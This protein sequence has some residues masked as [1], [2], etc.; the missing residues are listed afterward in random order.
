MLELPAAAAAATAAAAA[1]LVQACASQPA[2]AAA[3]LAV[4]GLAVLE[5]TRQDVGRDPEGAGAGASQR[6]PQIAGPLQL[7]LAASQVGLRA[8]HWTMRVLGSSEPA[9]ATTSGLIMPAWKGGHRTYTLDPPNNSDTLTI[10]PLAG[11]LSSIH[12][13]FQCR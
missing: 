10:T 3:A 6:E 4:A 1:V 2:P 5:V 12:A 13:A 9:T 7:I 11:T 8:V